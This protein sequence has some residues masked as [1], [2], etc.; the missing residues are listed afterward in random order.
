MARIR[1]Y[2]PEDFVPFS[3]E[4]PLEYLIHTGTPKEPHV[5]LGEL[6]IPGYYFEVAEKLEINMGALGGFAVANGYKVLYV[7]DN[8]ND[9]H[10]ESKTHYQGRK[11][12]IGDRLFESSSK[13]DL[14][15]LYFNGLTASRVISAQ[16]VP[17]SLDMWVTHLSQ[18]LKLALEESTNPILFLRKRRV[19]QTSFL[20]AISA[21]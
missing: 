10:T 9:A 5:A 6:T 17:Y 8:P 7:T 11:Y 19:A 14:L 1:P 13:G 15:A 3:R 4:V 18:Q 2:G 20:R 12:R 16:K 21:V